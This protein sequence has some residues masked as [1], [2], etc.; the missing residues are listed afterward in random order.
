MGFN[1]G[2]K[3]LI[4]V[5]CKISKMSRQENGKFAMQNSPSNLKNTQKICD[6]YD[7][8]SQFPITKYPQVIGMLTTDNVEFTLK[9]DSAP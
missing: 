3:W 6:E 4:K 9:Q 2:F 7:D 5:Q 8:K 1:S